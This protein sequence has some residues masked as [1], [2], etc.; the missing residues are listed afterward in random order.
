MNNKFINLIKYL[1]RELGPFIIF[2]VL[3]Y[4]LGQKWA[5][6]ISISLIVIEYIFLKIKKQKIT[7]LFYAFN[8]TILL[9][10]IFE[11]VGIHS[12]FIQYE[13]LIT[14]IIISIF[15]YCSIFKDKS[16]VQEITESQGRTNTNNSIDKRFFFNCYTVFWSIYFFSKGLIYF[17]LFNN[18]ELEHPILIRL[19]IGKFSLW[20]MIG[21][22][23]L[24]PERVWKLM[25]QWRLL[26]SYRSKS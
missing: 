3:D 17:W 9:F 26:P 6:C 2:Y 22:S 11:L 23:V 8:S 24:L 10:G 14:N 20:M 18:Q 12:H 4:Y 15:W 19:L 21:F 13:S 1:V 7:M 25:N 16:I 5:L